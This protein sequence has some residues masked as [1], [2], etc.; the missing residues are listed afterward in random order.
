MADDADPYDLLG[1]NRLTLDPG[2]EHNTD[3]ASSE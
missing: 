1:V 3:A 2:L